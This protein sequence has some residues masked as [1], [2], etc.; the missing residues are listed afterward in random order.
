MSDYEDDEIVGERPIEEMLADAAERGWF[1][2]GTYTDD[3]PAH[4]Y[5]RGPGVSSSGLKLIGRSPAHFMFERQHPRPRTRALTVG[6]AFHTLVLEPHKF[7][8]EFV[9]SP[10]DSYR[11]K[12]AKQWREDM[13]ASGRIPLTTHSDDPIWRPSEWDLIHRMRDAVMAHPVARHFFAFGVRERSLFWRQ[14]IELRDGQERFELCKVRFDFLDQTHSLGIDLKTTEDA[15]FSG[16][17]R[18]CGDYEYHLSRA[19]YMRGQVALDFGLREFVLV[20]VE[21]HPPYA[22]G[23]YVFDAAARHVGEMLVERRLLTYAECLDSG[24]WPAYP[25]EVRDLILP[26]YALRQPIR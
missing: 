17:A 11:T 26:A 22:V 21:K 7:D 6:T 23:C 8:D 2:P 18:S 16:F 9:A 10:F 25:V 4:V 3:M 24:E 5:H 19:F 20:A 14:R 1:E 12:D 15:S 13:I